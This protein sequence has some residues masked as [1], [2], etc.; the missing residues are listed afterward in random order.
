MSDVPYRAKDEHYMCH[1]IVH[2]EI[3]GHFDYLFREGFE[4]LSRVMDF[5]D[6]RCL[7]LFLLEIRRLREPLM[8]SRGS[9]HTE[10]NVKLLHKGM[11]QESSWQAH[12]P[13]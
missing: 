2:F 1:F 12:V 4:P 9:A 7:G 3:R 10:T 6:Q 5:Y 13:H 8:R 11:S